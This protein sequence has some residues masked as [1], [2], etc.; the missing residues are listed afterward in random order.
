M[1][2]NIGTP[3]PQKLNPLDVA[4][5]E[6]GF[7]R[8]PDMLRVVDK[9]KATPFTESQPD[10]AL[11][12]ISSFQEMG[13]HV[14]DQ[15]AQL[16]LNNMNAVLGKMLATAHM[17]HDTGRQTQYKQEIFDLLSV[18]DGANCH[19]EIRNLIDRGLLNESLIVEWEQSSDY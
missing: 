12:D 8:S 3:E 18:A 5:L 14:V 16:G 13:E 10:P 1:S 15:A 7:V 4:L 2:E 9:I 6:L 17:Y 19:G 11:T